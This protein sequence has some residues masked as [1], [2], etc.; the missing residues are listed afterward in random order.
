MNNLEN[1]KEY[2]YPHY[3]DGR[4][5]NK[6]LSLE[7]YPGLVT[8]PLT[9]HIDADTEE[10]T[11]KSSDKINIIPDTLYPSI[12]RLIIVMHKDKSMISKHS[13]LLIMNHK[14][15]T[16]LRF[17]PMN[18]RY[19]D[20]IN[21]YVE[22]LFDV[23]NYDF[24]VDGRHPQPK[25]STDDYCVAYVLKYAYFLINRMPIDFYDHKR[26]DVI[27]SDDDIVQFASAIE[28]LYGPLDTSVDGPPDIE[29]GRM[30]PTTTSIL[31]G[32]LGGAAIGGLAG[33]AGGA[34]V[35]GLGGAALGGLIGS[36]SQR[37]RR[38]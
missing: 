1:Y 16:I 38:Y 30:D 10:I 15:R 21:D 17:D 18:H 36:S 4:Y 28:Y 29:Y 31:V 33:G 24:S 35:G 34:V 12:I 8:K 25:D 9:L 2:T 13:N 6:V 32:G 27:C 7:E 11:T 37:R 26:D 20:I 23:Y 19:E 5:F 14:N 22:S 3:L